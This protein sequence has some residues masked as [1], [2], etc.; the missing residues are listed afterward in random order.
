MKLDT[1]GMDA[2]LGVMDVTDGRELLDGRGLTDGLTLADGAIDGW[3]DGLADG[4]GWALDAMDGA[5]LTDG[6]ADGPADGVVDGTAL[7]EVAG[8]TDGVALGLV[9]CTDGGLTAE[10]VLFAGSVALELGAEP[11]SGPDLN[12]ADA[13]KSVLPI[14]GRASLTAT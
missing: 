12:V 7:G 3:T 10:D 11:A 6:A 5:T 4:L 14:M 8:L 13:C 1:L 9:G 2:R